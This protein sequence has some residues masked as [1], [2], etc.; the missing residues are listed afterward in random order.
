[1]SV[2]HAYDIRGLYPSEI[3]E[4]FAYELGRRLPRQ[5]QAKTFMV[6]RDERQSSPSLTKALI[7][8]LRDSGAHVVYVGLCSTPEAYFSQVYLGLPAGVMVTASH[9]PGQFNG[10]KLLGHGGRAI[11][12]VDGLDLVE[13]SMASPPPSPA[14]TRGS[15]RR[16]NALAAYIRFMLRGVRKPFPFRIV[17]DQSNSAATGEKRALRKLCHVVARLNTEPDGSFPG[18]DPNPTL[19]SSQRD[20]KRAVR[21]HKA[22]FGVIFD[23]DADR[24]VFID[25]R[26][27][28]VPPDLVT[29][30][31]AQSYSKGTVIYEV[32]SSLAVPEKV[33][34]LGLKPV[35]SAAGRTTMIDVM[36]QKRA[37]LGGEKSGHY[38][39][40][41]AHHK[42]CVG[43]V[44]RKV[45]EAMLATGKS[46][47]ALS[48][49]LAGRYASLPERNFL[50]KDTKAVLARVLAAF[51]DRQRVLRLD[52]LSV[53]LKDG[54]WFNLRP[55][56]TEPGL[57]RL[58]AEA[59]V[60][61]RLDALVRRLER[62]LR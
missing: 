6:A 38:F 12:L 11:G 29:A 42:E 24:V 44:V 19:P 62:L 26:G 40:A 49:E 56:N 32:R 43:L 13:R 31:L 57:V 3:D 46:L 51:P 14:R 61:S 1:M 5:L 18:H 9:N 16:S 33:A 39:L 22:D 53:Y 4:G 47:A 60:R 15:F 20:L 8:G 27:R 17:L 48:D 45:M 54:S 34:E 28:M 41:E 23:G 25:A 58:N 10:F 59:P 35:L 2:F 30:I 55:S 37:V 7:S 50:V 36:M 52:G 21:E